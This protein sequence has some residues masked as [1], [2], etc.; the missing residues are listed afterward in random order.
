[1]IAVGV[2]SGT[3]LDGIDTAVVRI[4]PRDSG[5]AIDV[6]HFATQPFDGDLPA[7]LLCALPPNRGGVE[8]VA[9]LH[10]HLGEA[11]GRA[12]RAALGA[13]RADYVASH[14]QTIFHDGARGVTLQLGDAFAIREAVGATVCYDFRSADCAAG[15]Q[16]APLV[17]YVDALLFRDAH[18]DRVALNLGG[19]ANAT[20]LP[21]GSDDLVAFDTGPG[22]MVLDAFVRLRTGGAVRFDE[23]GRI[24]ARGR[25]CE[26]VL[27]AMLSDPYFAQLP[28][29]STGR[30]RFG[31]QFLYAHAALQALSTEDAAATLTELTAASAARAIALYA[32]AR[33]R[34]IVS[35]GGA[36][37]ATLLA[38]LADRLSGLRVERS[39]AMGISADAKEAVAFAVLGYETLRGRAAN[40]PAATGARGPVVLGGIAPYDL[41][42]LL[43]RVARECS[44]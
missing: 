15:G 24:A 10:R 34:V 37:N 17:P 26:P 36:N 25:A 8:E 5:Y 19:I 14:G 35:G 33:S 30:E 4:R 23:G 9:S 12:A 2:M 44:A 3:S 21:A 20:I 13:Q 22:N 43:D 39:D 6:V 16:G 40:V 18:E 29:K 42:A 7:A 27:E 32:P 1:M 38:R 28:P 31:E 41:Q 11:F